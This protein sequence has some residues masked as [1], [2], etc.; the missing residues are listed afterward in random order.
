M[1]L[2]DNRMDTLE[3]INSLIESKDERRRRTA[4]RN[5]EHNEVNF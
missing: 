1:P 5:T 3:K 4:A 2:A